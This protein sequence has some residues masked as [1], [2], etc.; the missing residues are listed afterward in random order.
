M[1]E[2]AEM[3]Y[4]GPMCYLGLMCYQSH[5]GNDVQFEMCFL[6][7]VQKCILLAE[8]GCLEFHDDQAPKLSGE[9][10]RGTAALLSTQK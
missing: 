3:C 8:P 5:S 1:K 10:R 2:V 4:L 6:E 7:C 9:L